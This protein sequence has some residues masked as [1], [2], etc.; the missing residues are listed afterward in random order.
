MLLVKLEQFATCAFHCHGHVRSLPS[1]FC[2]S[3]LQADPRV[4]V[5]DDPVEGG[6][7]N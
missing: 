6:K 3:R 7:V 1:A 5:V 2:V 4:E